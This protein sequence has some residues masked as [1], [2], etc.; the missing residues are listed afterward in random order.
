MGSSQRPPISKK[1]I[2]QVKSQGSGLAISA[3]PA[4]SCSTI[5]T[6]PIST[7][8]AVAAMNGDA[9]NTSALNRFSLTGLLD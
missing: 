3:W 7:K 1:K 5:S 6:L 2:I 8:G 9:A 4:I